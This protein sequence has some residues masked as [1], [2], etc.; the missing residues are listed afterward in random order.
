[1]VK[2]AEDAYATAKAKLEEIKADG[3]VTPEEKKAA[4]DAI[5]AAEALKKTADDAVKALPASDSKTA[6]QER[7]D[8]LT[9]LTKPEVSPEFADAT[10]AVKAAE[11]AYAT[12]KAKLEEVNADGKVTPEERAAAEEAIAAAAALKQTAADAVNALPASPTKTAL[13]GRVDALTD[14]TA[15]EVT[16]LA[17]GDLTLENFDDTG[18]AGDQISS[19]NTFTLKAINQTAAPLGTTTYQVMRPGSTEW[20]D[21]T[22]EQA[23]LADGTYQFRTKVTGDGLETVYSE[24][25]TVKIDTSTPSPMV[26]MD[27]SK[28][29]YVG[30]LFIE[31]GKAEGTGEVS[32]GAA[33]NDGSTMTIV[34]TPENGTESTLVLTKTGGAWTGTLPAGFTLDAASGK[35][36]IE[37]GTL[38]PGS[39]TTVTEY[40]INGKTASETN[41]APIMANGILIDTWNETTQSTSFKP[42][43]PPV[44]T[45]DNDFIFISKSVD[46]RGRLTT[47]EGDDFVAIG[48]P[49][50]SDGGVQD[51]G[52]VSMGDGND[53]LIVYDRIRGNGGTI[54]NMGKGNNILKVGNI[55]NNSKVSFESGDDVLSFIAVKNDELRH[56]FG[57]DSP[58]VDM[59]DGNN[60]VKTT[61]SYGVNFNAGT[62]TS[63][64]GNDTFELQNSDWRGV[65]LKTGAGDDTVHL[66]KVTSGTIELGGG[67]D[68]FIINGD[69]TGLNNSFVNGGSWGQ[70]TG[71]TINGGDGFDTFKFGTAGATLDVNGRL[72]GFEMI[73]MTGGGASTVKIANNTSNLNYSSLLADGATSPVNALLIKGDA[74]DKVDLWVNDAA[75]AAAIKAADAVTYEGVSY[76]VY[77]GTG[78]QVWIQDTILP[79]NIY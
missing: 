65:T 5:A 27:V 36:A 73:D 6:L 37:N 23:T 34:Y 22:A 29:E 17:A 12:A 21:T 30:D 68:T 41:R 32:A 61:E 66:G 13:Q 47:G 62:I 25:Q 35:L 19:D 3:K 26:Y 38:E 50:S 33:M 72:K 67:N 64:S 60:V 9:D 76:N 39:L 8:A 16:Q 7:V 1:A 4:D 11:D 18:V 45:A 74:N 10:A 52:Q 46:S 78:F 49:A 55:H 44:S 75:A 43:Y 28:S 40:N 14:I 51:G 71:G 31:P 20:V 15:P 69:L 59:G 53:T 24:P 54:V 70:V 48:S 79:V 56:N 63:G 58:S 42:Y 77:Q 57:Y 2:A